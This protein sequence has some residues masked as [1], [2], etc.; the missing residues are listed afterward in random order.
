MMSTQVQYKIPT[1]WKIITKSSYFGIV[2]ANIEEEEPEG[3][4]KSV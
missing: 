4:E 1:C 3:E 2:T